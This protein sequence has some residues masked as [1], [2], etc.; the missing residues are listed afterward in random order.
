MLKEN[1]ILPPEEDQEKPVIE[2]LIKTH[3]LKKM[4][5]LFR[6]WKNELKTKFVDKNETPIFTG[7]YEKIKDQ[8]DAFVAHK[9]SVKSKKMSETNKLNAAKKQLHHRT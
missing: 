9:K 1:F 8:W 6:R 4:T 3:A 7:R 2:P 5:E